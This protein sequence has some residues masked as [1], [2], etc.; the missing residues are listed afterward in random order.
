MCGWT[1]AA[2]RRAVVLALAAAGAEVSA[3]IH[4]QSGSVSPKILVVLSAGRE[5]YR[6]RVTTAAQEAASRYAEWLG[7]LPSPITITDRP[8][9]GAIADAPGTVIV[10][11]PWWSEP[12]SMDVES[13]VAYG[14]AREWWRSLVSQP[15]TRLIADS[16][17]WYLQSRVVER[18]FDL[19]FFVPG[20]SA[21]GVRFFGGT[22]PWAFRLLPL[23]R[24]TAGLGREDFLS[25]QGSGGTWPQAARR[26]PPQFDRLAPRGALAFGTLERYLG[27]PA[28]QGSLRVLA[29]RSSS[30]PMTRRE[31]EQTISD[32]AGQDLS[33]FFAPAFDSAKAF[34]YAVEALSTEPI[35]TPCTS[36]P[37]YQTRATV[38]RRGNA[39]FTGTS[40]QPLGPYEAGDAMELRVTFADGRHVST[41]WN[42][43]DA[44]RTFEYQS[45]ATAVG[46]RLDPDR[47]LLL[48]YDYLDD[49]RVVEAATNVAIGKWIASWLV[50]LQ[51]AT[52]SYGFLF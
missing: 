48:D 28:L 29:E 20:H 40:R 6:G 18:L 3:P 15:E 21:A 24:W 35:S 27:W 46:V 2:G 49:A 38:V 39:A 34:D 17:A 13:Q 8:W 36:P 31:V 10:E 37:C 23:S 26:L 32:A 9:R 12:A 16:I 45:A 52:L 42:G 1:R 7:P 5:P 14:L 25:S 50:W 47:V 33:W 30:T 22:V 19:G 44:S 41:R 43:R 4:A 11:P 51:D